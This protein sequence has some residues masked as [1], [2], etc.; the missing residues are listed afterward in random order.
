MKKET[1]NGLD[2]FL[3]SYFNI[4][5]YIVHNAISNEYLMNIQSESGKIGLY[6]IAHSLT[7]DFEN[8]FRCKDEISRELFMDSFLTKVFNQ[9]NND[10]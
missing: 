10:L 1:P 4:T 5:D 2:S 6:D 8:R 3:R 9:L 7:V